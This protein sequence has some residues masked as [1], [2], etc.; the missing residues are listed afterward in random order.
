[1]VFSLAV[2]VFVSTIYVMYIVRDKL[3]SSRRVVY[4]YYIIVYVV[5]LVYIEFLLKLKCLNH[6]S[7]LTTLL[8]YD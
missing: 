1:M 2:V 5:V 3:F 7:T 8:K 4:I 6:F